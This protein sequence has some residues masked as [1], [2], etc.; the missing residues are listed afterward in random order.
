M[1]NI[2]FIKRF[3]LIL[4]VA[5]FYQLCKMVYMEAQEKINLEI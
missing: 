2:D 5:D 3:K 4:T 1:R